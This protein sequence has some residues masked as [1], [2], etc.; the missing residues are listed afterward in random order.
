VD[1][2]TCRRAIGK[3]KTTILKYIAEVSCS[4]TTNGSLLLFSGYFILHGVKAA[5]A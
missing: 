2:N 3:I 1:G 4:K 5:R